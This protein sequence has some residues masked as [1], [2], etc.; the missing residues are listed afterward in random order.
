MVIQWGV[1]RGASGL[2]LAIKRWTFWLAG[3]K[4]SGPLLVWLDSTI[5]NCHV[6]HG[7]VLGPERNAEL[8][9]MNL[10]AFGDS[11]GFL[12]CCAARL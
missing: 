7:V 1:A 2:G 5:A 8:L 10:R 12:P 3:T 6:G 4:L 9:R 11:S